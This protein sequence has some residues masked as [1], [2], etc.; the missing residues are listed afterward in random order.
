MTACCA[1]TST[2]RPSSCPTSP[3]RGRSRPTARPTPS[4][5][6]HGVKFAS[7]NPLTAEDVVFSLQR[8]VMLDKTPAFILTQFGFT[9]DNVKDKMQADRSADVHD[10]DRQVVRADLR[11]QLPDRQRRRDRRQ[12]ARAVEGAERRPGLRLAEDQLRRLRPAQD[13]RMARQRDRR[14]RAQRQLLRREVEAAARRSTA[15]SRRRPR[16]GCCSRRATSTSPAT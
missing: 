7:G 2:I 1:T 4:S 12:E 14:A 5:C 10:R 8:A 15:T 9:K 13:P 11:P 3:S 16:S 6:E